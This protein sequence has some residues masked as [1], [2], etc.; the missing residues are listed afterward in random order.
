M[1]VAE[2]HIKFCVEIYKMQIAGRRFFMHEHPH[3]ASSWRMKEI[4]ELVARQDVETSECDMCA[5]GLKVTDKEGVA[6]S[7]KRTRVMSN[8]PEIIKR[9]GKQCSNKGD[10]ELTRPSGSVEPK[11]T[12][13]Q[14]FHRHADLTGGR[15]R[16]GQ[17]YPKEFCRAVCAGVAAQKRLYSLG[18]K[19]LPMMS[20]EE[21]QHNDPINELHE[22]DY[23]LVAWDD[24]SGAVLKPSMV[25]AA[26][27]EEIKYFKEM[28]VY[29]KVDISKCWEETGKSPVGVRWVDIN[30]G[31]DN[32]PIYRF[33]LLV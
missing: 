3:S 26:R 16:Q 15:A 18:L 32:N 10:A 30:K 4:V 27:K 22:D 25:K 31:D 12:R 6:F 1:R 17:V 29:E 13:D 21:I 19:A 11:L 33:E 24:Q 8:S 20:A 5:Y 2:Q 7:R 14:G 23:D 28:G 9:C